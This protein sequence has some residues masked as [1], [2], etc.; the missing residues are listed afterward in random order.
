MGAKPRTRCLV[1]TAAAT[2]LYASLFGTACAQQ[3]QI[4][5]AGSYGGPAVP[6]L[7]AP[8][9]PGAGEGNP[10]APPA[11]TEHALVA[12]NWLLYPTALAAFLYDTNPNQVATGAHASPGLRLVPSIVA[13]RTSGISKTDLYGMV[14]S[15]IY[16]NQPSANSVAARLGATEDYQPVPDWLLHARADFT[17][18][19]DLFSTFGT[20]PPGHLILP[21]NPTAVGLE[22]VASPVTYNQLSGEVAVQ[23]RF[24]NA[25]TQFGGS[26]VD[27]R[28]DNTGVVTQSPNGDIYT[29]VGRGGYWLTPDF[30]GYVE[31]EGDSRNFVTRS[32]GSSGYRAAAGIGS[33]QIGL[34]QGQIF[35]GYQAE[36][37]DSPGIGTVSS[38]VYGGIVH[39]YPLPELTVDF[40]VNRTLGASLLATTPTSPAGTATE[41]TYFLGDAAY[42]L[43]PEWT[44]SAHLGYIH[45]DYVGNVRRDN[46]W[47]IEP[48][49]TY[50]VWQRFG[51]TLD[52][53][54]L[55]LA[56]NV[57]RAGFSRDVITIGLSYKY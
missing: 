12:G 41:V 6:Q 34:F 52:Y 48:T 28:Y 38:S 36:S 54:H 50:S 16:T 47:T 43:A 21:L 1:L 17:R 53:Q 33:H 57:P 55:E 3:T 14:D 9:T 15:Q 11:S 23:K 39:Y 30:Y 2:C 37:Y 22:P 40:G 7:E 32:L 25:F 45:T 35:G 10:L 44:A 20:S 42:A 19:R 56:S 51:I 24:G 31:I 46:A 4:A 8:P 27:L 49:L 18:Q 29:G 13:E 26:I 5:Q